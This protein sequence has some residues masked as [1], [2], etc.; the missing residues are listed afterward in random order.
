MRIT[1][2][3]ALA[4]SC[5]LTLAAAHPTGAQET[6]SSAAIDQYRAAVAMQNRQMYDLAAKEWSTFLQQHGDDPLAAGAKHYLG[7]CFFQQAQFDK[8]ERSF[9]EVV[10]KHPESERIADSTLN[11]GLSQ[12]NQGQAGDQAAMRRAMKTLTALQQDHRRTAEAKQAPFYLAEAHYALGE[13]DAAIAAYER[14][15]ELT[16]DKK[17]LTKVLFG[18][19]VALQDQGDARQARRVFDQLLQLNPPRAIAAEA[20]MRRADTLLASGKLAAAEA[21]FSRLAEDASSPF[22]DY[23]RMQ[24]GAAQYGRK[25]YAAAAR[26]Y[27][28]VVERWPKS[29]F[30]GEATVAAG[31]C[32]YLAKSYDQARS[33]LQRAVGGRGER[34]SKPPT[35]GLG[36]R[37]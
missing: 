27:A 32:F 26:S 33:W 35:G 16:T 36:P 22:A 15:V 7:V 5:L 12:F 17:Q 2:S 30:A 20:R 31:K 9:A 10:N 28:E 3:L 13:L 11:L 19:G 24:L 23:V 37:W 21:E 18:Y 34:P 8:A 14:A 25:Q 29:E 6:S 1:R 4:V